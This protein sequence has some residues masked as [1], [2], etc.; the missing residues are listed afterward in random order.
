MVANSWRI[1]N[2]DLNGYTAIAGYLP[3]SKMSLA[4]TVTNGQDAATRGVNNSQKLFES[5]TG[6]L[7]PDHPG[8]P[9]IG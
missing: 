7:T 2:P 9:P 4:L 6:Y 3:S 5:I 8:A 1:Q